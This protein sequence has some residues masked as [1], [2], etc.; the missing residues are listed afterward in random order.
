M[1]QRTISLPDVF[2]KGFVIIQVIMGDI[3]KNTARKIYSSP[4]AGAQHENSLP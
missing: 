1:N 3:A 4:D 2:I